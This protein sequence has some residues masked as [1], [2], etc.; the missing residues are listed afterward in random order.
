M[1]DSKSPGSNTAPAEPVSGPWRRYLRFSMRG[2]IVL[3]L[4]KKGDIAEW[5]KA[6]FKLN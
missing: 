1:T 6:G 3:V 2:M 5:H 4:R